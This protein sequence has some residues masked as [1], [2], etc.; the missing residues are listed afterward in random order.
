MLVVFA[1]TMT[2]VATFLGIPQRE[3]EIVAPKV[4]AFY[5]P[6]YGNPQAMGGSGKLAHWGAINVEKQRIADSTNYPARG[7]VEGVPSG[8]YGLLAPLNAK[9]LNADVLGFST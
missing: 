1:V 5:Y 3:R 4:Y 9:W 6:W 7:K 8:A 2:G